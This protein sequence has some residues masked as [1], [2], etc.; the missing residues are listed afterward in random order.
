MVR[1]EDS[2]VIA[3][4]V[5]EV[6]GFISEPGNNPQWY[7]AELRKMLSQGA[8]GTPEARKTPAGPTAVGTTYETVIRTFGRFGVLSARCTALDPN[9]ALTWEFTAG[10]TKGSTDNW[11]MEPI[12]EKSTRLTR[13]FDLS[14]SGFLRLIQPII[15]QGTRKSHEEEMNN[16]KRI[17]EG[18]PQA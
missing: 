7:S 4:P 12:D 2:A 14:A 8:S 16:I 15:A 11:R 17:L 18:G 5:E 6:W 3:R 10:P 13:I 1:I 9:K